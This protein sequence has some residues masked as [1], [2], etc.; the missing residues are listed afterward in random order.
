[1]LTELK[2]QLEEAKS[3]KVLKCIC[4]SFTTSFMCSTQ[5]LQLRVLFTTVVTLLLDV[6]LFESVALISN[7][8]ACLTSHN[9]VCLRQAKII[10][11]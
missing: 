5:H 3:A 11:Q 7:E 1:M 8:K 4:C 2:K 9:V 10:E 6:L